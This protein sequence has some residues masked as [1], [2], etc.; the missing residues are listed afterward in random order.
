MDTEFRTVVR[1]DGVVIGGDG[2]VFVGVVGCVCIVDGVG[3]VVTFTDFA[4]FPGVTVESGV[5]IVGL[6]GVRL[7][8]VS[9]VGFGAVGVGSVGAVGVGVVDVVRGGVIIKKRENLGQCPK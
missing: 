6:D 5:F 9:L 3:V 2:S 7:D 1:G 4:D 8:G